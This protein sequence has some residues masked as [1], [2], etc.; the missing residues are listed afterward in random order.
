MVK[1]QDAAHLRDEGQ[2][3]RK[4]PT[5]VHVVERTY[6]SKERKRCLVC[7]TDTK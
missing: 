3:R 4:T 2:P 1:E 7:Y 5:F 6:T